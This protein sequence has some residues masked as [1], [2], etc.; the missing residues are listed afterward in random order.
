V[1]EI[2]HSVTKNSIPLV[3]GK[4]FEQ[5]QEK[6]GDFVKNIGYFKAFWIK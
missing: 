2:F 3:K 1:Q 4:V 5:F 6:N